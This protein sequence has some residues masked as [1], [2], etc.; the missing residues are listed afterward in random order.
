MGRSDAVTFHLECKFLVNDTAAFTL[1]PSILRVVITPHL[2]DYF[3]HC[4][5]IWTL[6]F[7]PRQESQMMLTHTVVEVAIDCP[8]GTVQ[9]PNLRMPCS[10]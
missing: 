6:G 3:D 7:T 10:L 2:H 8:D 5:D 4:I 1:Y 9:N